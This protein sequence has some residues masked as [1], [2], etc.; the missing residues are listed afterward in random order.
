MFFHKE[1]SPVEVL[2]DLDGEILNFYR[3]CQIHPNELSKYLATFIV[4]RTW[5][6]L[7]SITPPEALTDIQRAARFLYLQKNSF[8]GR[9]VGQNYASHVIQRPSFKPEDVERVITAAHLRLK[10]V[11]LEQLPYEQV[12]TK[13][14]RPTTFYFLDPPYYGHKLYRFNF[15]AEQFAE[16]A[17]RL[18]KLHARF[19]LTI[20]DVPEVR[21][22]F[23]GFH[24]LGYTLAYSAQR[25]VGRRYKELLIANFDMT[26]PH[27]NVRPLRTEKG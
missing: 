2:N 22:L 18:R 1:P 12:L 13:F 23:K 19:L 4:S 11:Q 5:F 17:E 24:M 10:S 14:D 6:R 9:V 25:S 16:M 26:K 27:D 3:V 20:N 7:V 8:G 15:S 21:Q